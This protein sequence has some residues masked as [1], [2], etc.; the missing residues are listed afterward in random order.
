MEQAIVS[1]ACTNVVQNTSRSAVTHTDRG[2]TDGVTAW[3]TNFRTSS[4]VSSNALVADRRDRQ[5]SLVDLSRTSIGVVTGYDPLTTIVLRKSGWSPERSVA[6]N[7]RSSIADDTTEGVG[8]GVTT[9]QLP[10]S[11]IVVFSRTGD[12]SQIG[13]DRNNI[14]SGS[15]V[16][17][18]TRAVHGERT[19][20]G[21][22]SRCGAVVGQHTTREDD[23][24]VVTQ[25]LSN[26]VVV[27]DDV[28]LQGTSVALVAPV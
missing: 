5:R 21:N 7:E 14:T 10:S 11:R 27:V 12:V 22:R 17:E 18:T 1:F 26:R 13:A 15:V 9:A 25:R 24:T 6:I 28:D 8:T 19:V 4:E 23:S 2:V 16:Q 20:R 3:R